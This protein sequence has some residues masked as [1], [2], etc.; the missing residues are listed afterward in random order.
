MINGLL[1]APLDPRSPELRL[2]LRALELAAAAAAQAYTPHASEHR[3]PSLVERADM[4]IGERARSANFTVDALA[5]HLSLSR[6]HLARAFA[7]A[8]GIP[9]RQRLRRARLAHADAA[10]LA[11]GADGLRDEELAHLC[12]FPSARALRDAYRTEGREPPVA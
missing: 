2:L 8:D 1:N 3:D 7:T 12:G 11:A 6:R 5:R 10:L 9:P 4:V